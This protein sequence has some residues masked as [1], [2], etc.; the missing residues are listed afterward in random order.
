MSQE[1]GWGAG[2]SSFRSLA[3]AFRLT[4]TQP[5]AHRCFGMPDLADQIQNEIASVKEQM[6]GQKRLMRRAP[7]NPVVIDAAEAELKALHSRLT[8]LKGNL[9]KYGARSSDD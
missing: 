4:G 1:R 7:D 3:Y 8:V 5:R 2:R 9:R 6:E